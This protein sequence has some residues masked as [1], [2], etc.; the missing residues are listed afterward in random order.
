MCGLFRK[1]T[2]V[3]LLFGVISRSLISEKIRGKMI[4]IGEYRISK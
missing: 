3:R 2:R 4:V 1:C